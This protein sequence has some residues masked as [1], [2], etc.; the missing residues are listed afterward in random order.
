MWI[1]PILRDGPEGLLEKVEETGAKWGNLGISQSTVFSIHERPKGARF[2]EWKK[3][4]EGSTAVPIGQRDGEGK[5]N[6]SLPLTVN[7]FARTR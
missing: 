7:R 4:S 2:K 1:S 6:L 5:S 3:L